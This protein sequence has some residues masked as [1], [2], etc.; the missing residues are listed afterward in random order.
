MIHQLSGIG[1]STAYEDLGP[2]S[3]AVRYM[4]ETS[5]LAPDNDC[6]L[7]VDAFQARASRND[8]EIPWL[9]HSLITDT[10]IGRIFSPELSEL[11]DSFA[12]W[13]PTTAVLRDIQRKLAPIRMS[14][15]RHSTVAE[16]TETGSP[17]S[18][19]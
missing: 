13:K 7:T 12:D 4:F 5:D 17:A 2:Y 9:L 11:R 14:P 15:L 1:H 19:L 3:L 8:Y 10:R 18:K 16:E 6:K